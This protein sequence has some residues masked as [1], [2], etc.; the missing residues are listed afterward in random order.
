MNFQNIT[1]I[2]WAFFKNILKSAELFLK[3]QNLEKLVIAN[4]LCFQ[5]KLEIS[6]SIKPDTVLFI[7]FNWKNTVC[8]ETP[9]STTVGLQFKRL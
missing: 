6:Y 8:P 9:S 4:D 2:N 5:K 7:M 1:K 3:C